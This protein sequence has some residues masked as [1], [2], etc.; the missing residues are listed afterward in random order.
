MAEK[1]KKCSKIIN[2]E[3]PRQSQTGK[4]QRN[5]II[6]LIKTKRQKKFIENNRKIM[7]HYL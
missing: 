4:T 7:T 5:F 6:K 2:L 1:F 3:S